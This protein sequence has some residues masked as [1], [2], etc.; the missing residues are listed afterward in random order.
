MILYEPPCTIMFPSMTVAS[1]ITPPERLSPHYFN[2]A[3]AS[4]PDVRQWSRR[5]MR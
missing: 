3:G 4:S 1:H 5:A 2:A